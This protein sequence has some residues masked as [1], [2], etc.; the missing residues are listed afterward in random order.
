MSTPTMPSSPR[1]N[2]SAKR[3]PHDLLGTGEERT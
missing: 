1:R 2:M 3:E